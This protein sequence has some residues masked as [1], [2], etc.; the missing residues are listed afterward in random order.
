[1]SY[2]KVS[3]HTP[4]KGVTSYHS[5]G[6]TELLRFNPHTHE[7]CDR[8]LNKSSIPTYCFNPHT[9]EGCDHIIYALQQRYISF[10]PHTHEG[11]DLVNL[12]LIRLMLSFNPHTHEGC[13]LLG[14]VSASGNV[15]F[16]PHTHEGCDDFIFYL[17]TMKKVSIHT[18]T[19]GVTFLLSCLR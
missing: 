8:H 2:L 3:I 6:T 12:I 11:C 13:D 14:D 15:G 10:N 9:H 4:T 7:G 5:I 1:M 17:C 19:K 16:N 18:P